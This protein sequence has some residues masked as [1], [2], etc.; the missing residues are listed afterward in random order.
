MVFDEIVNEFRKY[1]ADAKK[2]NRKHVGMFENS[3][4][5]RVVHVRIERRPI[6]SVSMFNLQTKFK[7]NIGSSK[8]RLNQDTLYFAE[9]FSVF[10]RSFRAFAK[11]GLL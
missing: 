5:T 2:F 4:V 10:V 1:S 3:D 8:E 7:S 9:S 6:L 11:N